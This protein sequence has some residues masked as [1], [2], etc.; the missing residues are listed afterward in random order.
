MLRYNITLSLL[1]VF[2][3]IIIFYR[4][5]GGS[6]KPVHVTT[7]LITN[8]KCFH[9]HILVYSFVKISVKYLYILI[10]LIAIE[11]LFSK[12]SSLSMSL[13][14]FIEQ[15]MHFHS[16]IIWS[17]FDRKSN[18][19]CCITNASSGWV[20]VTCQRVAVRSYRQSSAPALVWE[21]WIWVTMTFRILV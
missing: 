2:C 11:C 7:L 8:L 12:R 3:Q 18:E 1:D 5:I 4:D 13:Q 14:L 21:K 17:F 15:K 20:A 10:V 6:V 19:K 16:Y 9:I